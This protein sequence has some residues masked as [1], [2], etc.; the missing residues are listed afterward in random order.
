GIPFIFDPSQGLP[1]F[2]GEQLDCFIDQANWLT[3]NDYE[4]EMVTSKTG[5]T[6]AEIGQRLDAVIITRGAQGS[7]IHTGGKTHEIP[8][9]RPACHEDPTGAG[10]AYRVGLLY[11]LMNGLD[12]ETTGRCA[13]LMGCL[14]IEH[15]GT[16]NHRVTIDE[17]KERFADSFGRSL[18]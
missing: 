11:G 8:P 1:M 5:R 4:W 2:D 18:D 16:Q 3:V 12:W 6:L 14:A 13:S 17:F 7:V 15:H 10:D 9:A